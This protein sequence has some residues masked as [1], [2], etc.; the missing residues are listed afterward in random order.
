MFAV[1]IFF[2]SGCSFGAEGYRDDALHIFETVGSSIEYVLQNSQNDVQDSQYNQELLDEL[3][4]II[5]KAQRDAQK[6]GAYEEDMSVQ[7]A[8][9]EY[10]SQSEKY[11]TITFPALEQAAS[12]E[13]IDPEQMQQVFEAFNTEIQNIN[14]Q[15]QIFFS[16]LL[17]FEQAHSLLE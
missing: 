12:L 7:L 16:T 6:L 13:D 17:V 1:S 5:K 14:T 4:G 3:Q 10:L 11:F 2:L 8:L 15:K 9:T